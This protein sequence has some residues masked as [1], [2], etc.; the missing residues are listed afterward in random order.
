[1]PSGSAAAHIPITGR[2]LSKVERP[3]SLRAVAV[4]DKMR[5]AWIES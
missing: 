5:F 2:A 1:M 4:I 3:D